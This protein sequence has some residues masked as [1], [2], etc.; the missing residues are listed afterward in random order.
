MGRIRTAKIS[1]IERSWRQSAASS[2]WGVQMT[3]SVE[4][5][6]NTSSLVKQAQQHVHFLCLMWRTHLSSSILITFCRGTIKSVPTSSCSVWVGSSGAQIRSP[7]ESSED[8]RKETSSRRLFHPSRMSRRKAVSA[9]PAA[10]TET[11]LTPIMQCSGKRVCSIRTKT[12]RFCNC[13][14]SSDSWTLSNPQQPLPNC[15][16]LFQYVHKPHAETVPE[17]F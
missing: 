1:P 16:P 15:F 8:C 5:S 17:L 9:D 4:W 2:F 6:L 12:A 3:D 7:A 14:K 11:L 10:S 13:F